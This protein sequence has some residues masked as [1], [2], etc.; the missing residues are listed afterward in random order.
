[1]FVYI[2][3]IAEDAPA[4]SAASIAVEADG[5]A[6]FVHPGQSVGDWDVLAINDD[7]TGTNPVV[8]LRHDGEIC[9]ARLAANPQRSRASQVAPQRRPMP[10]RF[11]RR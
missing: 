8:W 3:T 4:A 5:P 9:S 10:Q 2:V 7:W 11:F 1:V 6:H